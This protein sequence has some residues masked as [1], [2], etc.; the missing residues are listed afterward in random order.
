MDRKENVAP[1]DLARGPS[2]GSSSS[3]RQPAPVRGGNKSAS[4]PGRVLRDVQRRLT[5]VAAGE[6][7]ASAKETAPFLK[8]ASAPADASAEIADIDSRLA[9][10]QMF[11]KE[12]KASGSPAGKER[13]AEE[14]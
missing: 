8:K 4:S 9:A 5:E 7:K 2:R 12:A 11:L 1:G 13:R 10:L 6:K 14:A 3:R